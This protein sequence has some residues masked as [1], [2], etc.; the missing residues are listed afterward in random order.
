MVA[1]ELIGGF[2]AL[3]LLLSIVLV[4]AHDGT[5][6]GRLVIAV[7]AV[8]QVWSLTQFYSVDFSKSRIDVQKCVFNKRTIKVCVSCC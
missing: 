2:A 3:L 7:V 4:A 8:A 1:I 5:A 6:S